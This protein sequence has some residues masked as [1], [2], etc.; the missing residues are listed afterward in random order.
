MIRQ[1]SKH[2]HIENGWLSARKK[3]LHGLCKSHWH[4][5]FEL[6]Y[7]VSGSGVY[8]IDG[9]RYPIAPGMLFWMSPVNFHRVEAERAQVFNIMFSEHIC[10][11]SYLS[12]LLAADTCA[13]SVP[14]ADAHYLEQLMEQLVRSQEDKLLSSH[15]LSCILAKLGEHVAPREAAEPSL[16]EATLYAIKNFRSAPS[17]EQ[18]ASAAGF[19]P[20]YFSERFKKQHGIGYKEY[21]NGLQF[22]YAKKL[23]LFTDMTVLEIS[24][25]CGF[26]EYSNFV[27][28]FKARFGVT[29]SDFRKKNRPP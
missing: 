14:P 22:D 5:F 29:P 7:I 11:P 27:R 1:F 18:A 12:R 28:R 13:L 3:E 21:V 23:L 9:Q 15:L 17:L 10:E 4:E 25:E 19:S 20:A 24:V 16:S 8:L 6:E 26:G 2:V